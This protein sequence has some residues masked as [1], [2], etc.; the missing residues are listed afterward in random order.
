[1]IK[2]ALTM[3]FATMI[4]VSAYSQTNTGTVTS[5]VTLAEGPTNY[6]YIGR[7]NNYICLESTT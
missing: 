2:I 5:F 1:M 6:G 4:S 7:A 3:A